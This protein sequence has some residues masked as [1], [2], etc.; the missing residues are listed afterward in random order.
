LI[1]SGIDGLL[2]GN[3][4]AGIL[5]GIDIRQFLPMNVSAWDVAGNVLE[6]WC[7]CWMDKDYN[8]PLTPEG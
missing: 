7:K 1:A 8:S 5:L 4:D 6:G 3:Y 2:H